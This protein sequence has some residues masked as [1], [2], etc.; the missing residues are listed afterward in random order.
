LCGTFVGLCYVR[1]LLH[2][3]RCTRVSVVT[4]CFSKG[5]STTKP[6]EVSYFANYIPLTNLWHLTASRA[7]CLASHSELVAA[8]LPDLTHPLKVRLHRHICADKLVLSNGWYDYF[9][10][11][12]YFLAKILTE[13][14]KTLSHLMRLACRNCKEFV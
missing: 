3:R 8:N 10:S 9:D 5:D 7:V 2:L 6:R 13:T 14:G 4:I 12:S 1:N 11:F